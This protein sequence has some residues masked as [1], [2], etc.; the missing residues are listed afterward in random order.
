MDLNVLPQIA[1]EM[2]KTDVNFAQINFLDN[3]DILLPYDLKVFP[4]LML[5]QGLDDVRQYRGRL[6]GSR[7]VFVGAQ[8]YT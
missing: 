5:F 3:G 6:E 8:N 7:Y 2:R 1:Y 4:H